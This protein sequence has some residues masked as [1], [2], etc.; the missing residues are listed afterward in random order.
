MHPQFNFGFKRVKLFLQLLRGGFPVGF[1]HCF[2][3]F[4]SVLLIKQ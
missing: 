2:A 1:G 3:P 4:R